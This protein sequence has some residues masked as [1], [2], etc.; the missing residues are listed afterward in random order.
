MKKNIDDQARDDFFLDIDENVWKKLKEQVS[1][2]SMPFNNLMELVRESIWL[3]CK[4]NIENQLK[5]KHNVS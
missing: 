4:N 2:N 3:Q 5:E 1:I